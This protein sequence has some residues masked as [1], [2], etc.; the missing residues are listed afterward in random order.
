MGGTERG[1]VMVFT[2]DGKGKSTAAFGAALRAVG[3]GWKVLVVQ[4]V[5]APLAYGEVVA[6][7]RLAPDLRVVS[8]GKGFVREGSGPTLEEHAAAAREALDLCR[9]AGDAD[10]LVMDEACFAVSKGLIAAEE[11]LRFLDGRPPAMTVILTGRGAPREIL[12]RADL[13]TEMREIK[14][15]YRAGV[16]ARK[17]IEY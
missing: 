14:H 3:A 11:V 15:P 1:L 6:A 4:F 8:A 13:V 17:G 12:D 16:K 5:K 9:A 7:G 2:G 10:L